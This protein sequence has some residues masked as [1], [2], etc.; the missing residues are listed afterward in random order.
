MPRNILAFSYARRA[1]EPGSRERIRMQH[2][3]S[4]LNH[5]EVIVFT[6]KRDGFPAVQQDGTLTLYATNARTKLGMLIRAYQLGRQV[7]RKADSPYVVS[8]QDPFETS[9]LGKLVTLGS[10]HTH[11]VQ[12]HGDIFNPHCYRESWLWPLRIWFAARTL[13]RAALVR[14]VSE[15][16]KRSL[17]NRG[18]SAERIQ[19]LPIQAEL[20]AFLQIGAERQVAQQTGQDELLRLL[21]VGRLSS[22]KNVAM[23]LQTC[24]QLHQKSVPITL[25]IVGDGPLRGTL[26]QFVMTHGLSPVVT[27]VGWSEQIPGEMARADVFCLTSNHEGWAMVL[28]EA[29]AAQMAVVTTDVGCAGEFIVS[30]ETGLVV[31][32]GDVTA[33]AAAIHRLLDVNLRTRLADAAYQAAAQTA[34]RSET[35]YDAWISSHM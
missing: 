8:T 24:L 19:V 4:R 34:M 12:V 1:L 28:Q 17:V 21:F 25:R 35:Y 6:R 30:D 23:L 20:D 13:R 14:V 32:V 10:Q 7:L 26:E 33:L 18:V 15:R 31:P 22:E 11:H 3:A 29:A 16:I 2:Y 27:F 9:L 5:Y